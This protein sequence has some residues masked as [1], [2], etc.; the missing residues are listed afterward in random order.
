MR[1]TQKTRKAINKEIYELPQYDEL[2]FRVFGQILDILGKHGLK[3]DHLLQGYYGE[4]GKVV[5]DIADNSCLVYYWYWL[6][7]RYE[8]TYYLS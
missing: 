2:K 5:V 1:L 4:N 6:G 7:T 3:S 8:L